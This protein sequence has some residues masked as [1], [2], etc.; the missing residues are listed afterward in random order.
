MW[1]QSYTWGIRVINDER[2]NNHFSFDSWLTGQK[3]TRSRLS[4]LFTVDWLPPKN[5]RPNLYITCM[6]YPVIFSCAAFLINVRHIVHRE[7]VP[8]GQLHCGV[9]RPLREDVRRICGA[10]RMRLFKTTMHPIPE[11]A[12]LL[13][14]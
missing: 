6:V 4:F 13:I 3:T 12:S 2:L 9:L 7:F 5:T 8:Q 11:L 10:S 1:H 14:F